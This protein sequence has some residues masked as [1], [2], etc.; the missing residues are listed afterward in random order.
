M[1]PQDERAHNTT[2]N[3][4][5]VASP[6][7]TKSTVESSAIQAHRGFLSPLRNLR[8]ALLGDAATVG[9]SVQRPRIAS[10]VANPDAIT[11]RV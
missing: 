3:F 6:P 2:D 4:H 9:W 11:P 5:T 10:K 1:L 8:R 7:V